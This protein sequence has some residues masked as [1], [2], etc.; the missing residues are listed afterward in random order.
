MLNY[1]DN[2]RSMQTIRTNTAVVDSFP[3]HTQGREDTVEVRR[4]LCR[5][6]PGHQHFIVTFKND[7][8]RAEKISNSTSLVKPLAEVIVRN[9]KAR[10]VLEE[11]HYDFNEKIESSIL[12]YMNGKSTHQ[13]D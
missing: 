1:H 7:V 11:H 2:T 3:V 8:E 4:M 9:N 13:C 12:Q 6:S 5:R 10:F